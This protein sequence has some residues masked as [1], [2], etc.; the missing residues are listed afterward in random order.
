MKYHGISN[1][2]ITIISITISADNTSLHS[3]DLLVKF[4]PALLEERSSVDY[5]TCHIE[6]WFFV[7]RVVAQ[8]YRLCLRDGNDDEDER[9]RVRGKE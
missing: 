4:D 5:P 6:F 8:V 2:T 3:T 1:I 9:V 7:Q